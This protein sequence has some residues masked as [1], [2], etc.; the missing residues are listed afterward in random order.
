[1]TNNRIFTHVSKTNLCFAYFRAIE[2]GPLE[3]G[4]KLRN[5]LKLPKAYKWAVFEWFYSSI[6]RVLL[7]EENDFQICLKES[8]PD[9]KTRMMN[10]NE[11]RIIRRLLG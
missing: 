2:G 1:M 3:I 10:R 5:M 11:W 4:K 9:L 7:N 8:F 6:D